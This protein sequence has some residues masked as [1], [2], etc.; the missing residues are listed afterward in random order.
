MAHLWIFDTG[1]A[2]VAHPLSGDAVALDGVTASGST[3]SRPA[4][5]PEARVTLRR[6]ADPPNSWAVLTSDPALRLN[7]LPVPLGVAVL[8]DR[9][10]IRAPGITAWFSTEQRALVEAFPDAAHAGS[11][12]RCKQAITTA[13]AAVRCPGCGLWHH[14][15]VEMPCWS[16][17]DTC[18][19]CAQRT[20]LDAGFE[21]TPE[22]L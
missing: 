10:E 4:A 15:S 17:A 5:E 8:D 21:W 2:W 12:P 9:D 22:G 7:G 14:E 18:A 6:L 1:N 16:Y 11:C 13:T 20:A 3:S 19:S